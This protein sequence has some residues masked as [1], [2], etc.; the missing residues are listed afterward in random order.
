MSGIL[1]VKNLSVSFN[2][3]NGELQILRD[4]SFSIN[5]GEVLAIAGES[6]SG[7]SVLCKTVMKLLPESASIKSGRILIDGVDITG[8]RQKDMDKLRGNVLSM[9][10]QDPV[11]A[12]NPSI[13]IGKQIAEA[14]R[15]RNPDMKRDAVYNQVIKLMKLAGITEPERWYKLY[16]H[17][18]SG[19]MCQRSVIAAALASNP[20]ILFADEPTTSLDVITQAQ[21]LDLLG[22]I[23]KK[24]LTAIV[25]VSHDMGAVA[26]IADRVLVMYA[27]QIVETGKVEDIFYAPEHPYTL[28]LIQSVPY[29]KY[30]GIHC[31]SGTYQPGGGSGG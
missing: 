26:R 9:I 27:G 15:V 20:K 25:F 17:N 30:S 5:K 12:L 14:V 4:V 23:Q 16:P 21:I 18:L 3:P 10:F 7:K 22:D 2:T 6:G 31:A 13:S 8:Y 28:K 29:F 24:F 19:G 11:A 1:E